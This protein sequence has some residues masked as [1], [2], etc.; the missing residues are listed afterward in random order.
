MKTASEHTN[1]L[2]C[3][4]KGIFAC[5]PPESEASRSLSAEV[6]MMGPS[7]TFRDATHPAETGSPHS[8]PKA[9]AAEV[10]P[11]GVQ[12]D[13]QQ[14]LIPSPHP[15]SHRPVPFSPSALPS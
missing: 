7:V 15:T 8:L 1:S 9:T 4:V 10:I 5:S 12:R 3:F 2:L 13:G 11:E 6:W 14:G